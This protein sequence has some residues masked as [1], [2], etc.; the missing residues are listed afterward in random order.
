MI[1]CSASV[2]IGWG[3]KSSYMTESFMLNL[4]WLIFEPSSANTD[5]HRPTHTPKLR[6]S[7]RSVGPPSMT[8]PP[9]QCQRQAPPDDCLSMARSRLSHCD[10]QPCPS[11]LAS[12]TGGI[13]SPAL[14]TRRGAWEHHLGRSSDRSARHDC[15]ALT[16]NQRRLIVLVSMRCS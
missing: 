10:W 8:P 13:D 5:Q 14:T 6:P 4:P 7:D 11:H 9:A 2:S 15:S 12:T 16:I 3:V 1:R